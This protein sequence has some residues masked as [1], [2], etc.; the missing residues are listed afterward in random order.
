MTEREFEQRVEAAADKF[1]KSITKQWDN[2]RFFRIGIKSVSLAAEVALILG[3]GYLV[4]LGHKTVAAWCFWLG[5]A[6]IIADIVTAIM[7]R[8]R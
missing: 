4:E 6:G 2:N 1:D 5:V 7:F 8:R 3:A